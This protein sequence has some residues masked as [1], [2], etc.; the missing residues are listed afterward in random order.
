MPDLEI[1]EADIEFPKKLYDLI[2]SYP[3]EFGAANWEKEMPEGVKFSHYLAWEIKVENQIQGYAWIEEKESESYF[4]SIAI[5]PCYQRQGIGRA[6][7][8]KIENAAKKK[9]ISILRSQVNSSKGAG[10]GMRKLLVENGY[11]IDRNNPSLIRRYA[12]MEDFKLLDLSLPLH[13]WKTLK[14]VSSV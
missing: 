14:D 2:K 9:G 3:L 5:F 8:P 10:M 6:T 12:K 1:L 7:I 4:F 13:F 11:S